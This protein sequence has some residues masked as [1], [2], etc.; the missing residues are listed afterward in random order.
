M[1]MPPPTAG[2]ANRQPHQPPAPP[3]PPPVHSQPIRKGNV[4]D[5]HCPLRIQSDMGGLRVLLIWLP[6]RRPWRR[7][8]NTDFCI[9]LHI[10]W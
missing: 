8:A 10:G 4:Q 6:S 1:I 3:P 7:V 9:P 2:S 5:L